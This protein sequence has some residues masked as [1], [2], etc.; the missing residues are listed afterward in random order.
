MEVDLF[1]IS[2]LNDEEK[3]DIAL[4]YGGAILLGIGSIVLRIQSGRPTGG[5]DQSVFSFQYTIAYIFLGA[6]LLLRARSRTQGG[7]L[8]TTGIVGATLIGVLFPA[9]GVELIDIV[10]NALLAL[11]VFM[12][13][14]LYYKIKRPTNAPAIGLVALLVIEFWVYSVVYIVLAFFQVGSL[15]LLAGLLILTVIAYGIIR[16]LIREYKNSY[17]TGLDWLINILSGSN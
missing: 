16:T 9:P 8:I 14:I 10:S 2:E 15:L 13:G 11:L 4:V 5:I 6:I 1:G 7:L 3:L 12:G 17:S